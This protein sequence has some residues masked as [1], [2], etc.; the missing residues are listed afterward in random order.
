[1]QRTSVNE[2]LGATIRHK[3]FGPCEIVDITNADEGKFVGKVKETNEL[4]KFIF[5]KQ[6]FVDIDNYDT[7]EF[8]VKSNARRTRAYRKADLSKYRNHPLVKELEK[9]ETRKNNLDDYDI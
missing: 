4:K 3:V 6:F 8:V 5:S 7:V 9:K 1:M 2:L